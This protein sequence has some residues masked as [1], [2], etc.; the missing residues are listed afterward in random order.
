M[1]SRELVLSTLEFRNHTGI[2]PVDLWSLPW[3]SMY[4]ADWLN[5][6]KTDFPNDIVTCPVG[7]TVPSPTVGDPYDGNDYVDEWG[8][9]FQSIQPGAIGEVKNPIV[10][11]EDEWDTSR[12]RFPDERLHIDRD[13]VNRF[14]A[15]ESRFVM[16]GCCPRPFERL[17]FLRGTQELYIDLMLEPAGMKEFLQKLHG[18]FL[19]EMEAWAKTDV[20]ALMYMDDAGSQKALLINPEV[21]RQYFKPCYKDYIDLAHAYG[22][23]CFMHSDG[24]ILSIYPDLIEMG[25]DALNS[26]LFCMGLDELEKYAGKITF[27]GEIDRQNLLPHGTTEDIDRAVRDVRSRLWKNG[28]CIAECEFGPGAKGENVYRVFKTWR[29]LAAE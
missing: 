24:Y 28:G 29:D 19:K 13:A 9:L 11:G 14:C 21:W 7:Q 5:R 23:K 25:L 12:V 15:G 18:Y 20:D 26:Q 8:V 10:T 27:W 2:A 1:D 4:Q 3:A 17:Q 16:G 6:V 22:K